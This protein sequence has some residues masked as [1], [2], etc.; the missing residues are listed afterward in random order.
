M[1]ARI[2]ITVTA[3]HQ[4]GFTA[5]ELTCLFNEERHF[6]GRVFEL[7]DGWHYELSSTV[8][9]WGISAEQFIDDVE[10]AKKTLQPYVNRQGINPPDRL[11]A[12]EFSLWLLM[13]GGGHESTVG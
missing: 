13:K 6:I 5:A 9:K 3:N 12:A 11:S 1:I 10:R 2:E 4:E 8:G 7:Q